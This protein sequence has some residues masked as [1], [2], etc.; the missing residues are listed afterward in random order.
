MENKEIKTV[1]QLLEDSEFTKGLIKDYVP[2]KEFQTKLFVMFT[3]EDKKKP[4]DRIFINDFI[5]SDDYNNQFL[6]KVLKKRIEACELSNMINEEVLA[7]WV[8]FSIS[9]PGAAIIYLIDLLE[10]YETY[11][12]KAE[13]SDI[14]NIYPFGFYNENTLLFI[15]DNIM[16]PNKSIW[17]KI[18]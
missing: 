8:C 16:K 5:N 2:F 11:K 13:I 12:R 14:S 15:I 17:S 10:F 1:R 3:M 6:T 7:M 18:Y 4:E 9:S